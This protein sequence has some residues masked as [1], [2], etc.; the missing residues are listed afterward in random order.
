V[1]YPADYG[2]A[3]DVYYK[4]KALAEAGAEI[5][6]HCFQ[7]GRPESPQ[8]AQL[9]KQVWYYPRL[10][11]FRGLSAR[12]PYIV[13]SRRNSLL[14]KRL[15]ET[16]APILFE[17]VHATYYLS[18]PS[19][20]NR[21]KA[22]RTHNVEH[23]YYRQL[24]AK[25]RSLFKRMYYGTE[26]SLLQGYESKL[27]YAQAFFSLSAEDDKYFA[28]QYPSISHAFIAPFQPYGQVVSAPGR[29]EYSLYHGNLAHGENIEAV[30]FLLREVFSKVNIPF[31]VAGR[32]PSKELIAACDQ[33]PNCTLLANP[34]SEEMEKLVRDAQIHVLPTFQQSGMKL[35]LL[36]ALFSGRHV[37][38]NSPMLHGTGLDKCCSVA[39]GAKEMIQRLKELMEIPF[40]EGDIAR[41]AEMLREQYD[42][43]RNAQRLLTYLPH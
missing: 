24:A 16:E 6:L 33:V 30:L 17:G 34:G 14:L 1:P 40:T 27:Q 13:N 19:L 38:V 9:C 29:G 10:T 25:E 37:L 28:S 31:I 35:K 5:Y 15:I 8:L 42:N 2:G 43:H 22:I 3:I 21:F 23:D 18:H 12:L 39:D 7:Y 26:A 36:Y 20:R 11:G 41:R 4:I 32:N